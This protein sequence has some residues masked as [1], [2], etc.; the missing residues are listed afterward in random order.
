MGSNVPFNGFKTTKNETILSDSGLQLSLFAPLFLYKISI[1][2]PENANMCN[3][4]LKLKKK[5]VTISTF[6]GERDPKVY[7]LDNS[8]PG[9]HIALF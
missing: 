9:L 6:F 4:V 2:E 5:G 1:L 8:R 7:V 3:N